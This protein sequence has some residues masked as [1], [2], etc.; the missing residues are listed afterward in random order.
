MGDE[1]YKASDWLLTPWPGQRL[2][3][4]KDAYNF[5]QSRM[6]INIECSFGMLVQRWG[7]LWKPIRIKT[8]KVPRLLLALLGL[9]N[10][11]TRTGLDARQMS[12]E[13]ASHMR[14]TGGMPVLRRERVP[15]QGRR[16][17]LENS[18]VRERLTLLLKHEG[19]SRPAR[20]Q[21]GVNV[22]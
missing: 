16:R 19:L 21:W 22:K 2:D 11:A 8:E 9:N 10:I 15:I 6:R 7:V 18:T 5:W 14:K 1:A 17:D 12:A 20:S 13:T 4:Y 3:V